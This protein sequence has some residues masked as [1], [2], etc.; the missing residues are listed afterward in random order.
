M[1]A[2]GTERKSFKILLNDEL[3]TVLEH[4]YT[5][6]KKKPERKDKTELSVKYK[7][8]PCLLNRWFQSRR[9]KDTKKSVK[10]KPKE[11]RGKETNVLRKTN[12]FS[13]KISKR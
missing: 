6:V 9:N 13:A 10:E 12:D 1:A 7:I 8:D 2:T 3:R 5:N 11:K 4:Y